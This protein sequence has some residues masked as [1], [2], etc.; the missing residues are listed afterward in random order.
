MNITGH[1][2]NKLEDPFGILS[3]ERYEFFLDIE[4]PKDDELYTE[5]GL[6]LKVLY[7]IEEGNSRISHYHIIENTTEKILDFEL[8]EDEVKMVEAYCKEHVNEAD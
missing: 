4:V 2:V 1:K 3:G 5:N 6:K 7:I 8:E